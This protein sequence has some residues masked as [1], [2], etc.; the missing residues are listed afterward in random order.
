MQITRLDVVM[1]V[2]NEGWHV[3][4]ALEC[5]ETASKRAGL[6]TRVILVD[7]GSAPE[8]ASVLDKLS[9]QGR[10]E[11][12]RQ[13]NSGRFVARARGL[14]RA[15]AEHVL[16]LDARV[17]IAPDSLALI[18][19]SINSGGVPV[20]NF[21]VSLANP[22]SVWASFW[23]GITAV[24][25]RDYFAHKTPVIVGEENF[26]RYP[27]GTTAFL[28]PRL[29]LQEAMAQ[30]SSS[31]ADISLASDDTKLIRF[32][33]GKTGFNLSPAVQ[34]SYFGKDTPKKWAK[35]C[36]FRGST[37][38]DGYLRD[39]GKAG[40]LLGVLAGAVGLGTISLLKAPRTT[41]ALAA[42]ASLGAGGFARKCGAT[43]GESG[44]VSLLSVP[45]GAIFGTGLA[46]GLWLVARADESSR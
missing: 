16:L 18:A 31:F 38:V 27:K 5:V 12:V 13:E 14:E 29:L 40:A 19:D 33:A 17:R 26:D 6:D 45:F 25:W 44:A 20:W 37:F 3:E 28:A 41:L 7:D 15:S 9:G 32:I 22:E 10:I 42:L 21:D 36:L 34:C 1:P 24:W 39:P 23:F 30:F 43:A 11:L 35:Q 8:Y 4:E 46:R 2:Y